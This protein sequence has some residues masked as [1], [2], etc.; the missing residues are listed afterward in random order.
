[1]IYNISLCLFYILQFVQSLFLFILAS[2]ATKEF[3]WFTFYPSSEDV[4]L[5][6]EP[7]PKKIAAFSV[8]WYSPVF[9]LMSGFEHLCCLVFRQTYEYYIA[10]NQNPFRWTEYTFSASLMRVMIGQLVGISDVHLL[11]C[12]FIMTAASIQCAATHE[13]VNAKARADGFKQHWRPFFMGWLSHL[14]TWFLI[15]NYFAHEN[16]GRGQPTFLWCIIA[17]IF[18]LDASFAVLFTLQWGQFGP[19]KGKFCSGLL[20]ENILLDFVVSREALF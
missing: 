12:I 4:I 3:F 10:R 9:I 17:F 13:S 19:F 5:G 1:M 7:N 20:T 18:V 6:A 2:N 16:S 11:F 15:F 8:L 14:S